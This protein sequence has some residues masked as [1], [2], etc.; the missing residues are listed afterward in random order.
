MR[1]KAEVC[2][3]LRIYLRVLDWN[4]SKN[5]RRRIEMLHKVFVVGGKRTSAEMTSD[6]RVVECMF[7]MAEISAGRTA[8]AALILLPLTAGEL[9]NFLD[10]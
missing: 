3:R 6:N 8:S 5:Q 2:Q 1:T 4:T 10:S 9:R 7:S